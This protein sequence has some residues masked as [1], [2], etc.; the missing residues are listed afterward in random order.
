MDAK[1]VREIRQALFSSRQL[2]TPIDHS[3]VTLRQLLDVGCNQEVVINKVLKCI[4]GKN[5]SKYGVNG[6]VG[7]TCWAYK[8][9]LDNFNPSLGFN[10]LKL[11]NE[12]SVDMLLA[13]LEE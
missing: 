1:S 13:K 12:I 9:I 8:I 2:E 6:F 7:S 4:S 10:I 11:L 5:F 3:W